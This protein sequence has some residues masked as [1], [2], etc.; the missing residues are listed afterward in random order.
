MQ[1]AGLLQRIKVE[2]WMLAEASVKLLLQRADALTASAGEDQA[3]NVRCTAEARLSVV[4]SSR[5]AMQA[6][7]L[8]AIIAAMCE[9]EGSVSVKL[10]K[11]V[12]LQNNLWQIP[13]DELQQTVLNEPG[14]LFRRSAL[15]FPP[16]LFG[17]G[18]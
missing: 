3:E 10:L 9:R 7:A 1:G 16:V 12:V 13:L 2:G 5:L 6:A 4:R 14:E 18:N 11:T 17:Y 8:R 15:L